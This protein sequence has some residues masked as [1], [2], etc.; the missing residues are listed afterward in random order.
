MPNTRGLFKITVVRK[1][2]M[3]TFGVFL[4]NTCQ[5]TFVLVNSHMYKESAEQ[6]M[7]L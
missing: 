1:R 6:E 3:I 5:I 7:E 2:I 4:Q